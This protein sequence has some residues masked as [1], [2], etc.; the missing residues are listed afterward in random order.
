MSSTFQTLVPSDQTEVYL[1]TPG[2]HPLDGGRFGIGTV[3]VAHFDEPI[4][5]RAAAERQLSVT[6]NPPVRGSWYWVDDQNAHWR[7]EKYYAPRHF[8]DRAR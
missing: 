1:T 8:S 7:P 2:G 5:D 3:V 6:T 4:A